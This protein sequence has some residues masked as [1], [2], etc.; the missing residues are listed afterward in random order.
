MSDSTGTA[1]PQPGWYPNPSGEPGYRWW[2]GR[3]WTEH[4]RA[5]EPQAPLHQHEP[6]PPKA[7]TPA[8][9]ADPAPVPAPS[10]VTEPE[11]TVPTAAQA[12]DRPAYGERIPGYQTPGSQAAGSQSPASYGQQYGQGQ[13]AYG[14]QG[15]QA[16][17]QQGQYG[18]GQQGYGAVPQYGQQPPAY[19][20][21]QSYGYGPTSFPK[22][23][24]GA[25]IYNVFIWAIV[26]LPVLSIILNLI[27]VSSLQPLIEDILKQAQANPGAQTVPTTPATTPFQVV[28]QILS[29]LI[30][31]AAVVLGYFDWK[32]LKAQ[33]IARPFHWAWG[34]FALISPVVYVIGRSVVVRRRAGR[35][36]LPMWVSI[37][38]LV[39]GFIVILTLVIGIFSAV[40][41]SLR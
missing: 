11:T 21:Q 19:G 38:I 34:F 29:I 6:I 9:Q 4:V 15:Q 31:A 10:S 28:Q 40:A 2:D 32:A 23:P 1:S 24:E 5:P 36:L 30:A 41:G 7:P 37:A 3:S 20:G 35:G 8:A 26:A 17:G 14:Q 27:S 33:G 12:D 18:Q 22:A 39:I 25:K 16:Y 13:Q